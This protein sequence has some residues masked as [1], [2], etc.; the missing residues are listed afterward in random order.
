MPASSTADGSPSLISGPAACQKMLS[1]TAGGTGRRQSVT[2]FSVG[3][4][5]S[6]VNGMS[7]SSPATPRSA[8]RY[9]ASGISVIAIIS[10]MTRG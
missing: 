1:V 4:C 9:A 8:S 10:R 7:A 6:R 5:H 2:T 3:T